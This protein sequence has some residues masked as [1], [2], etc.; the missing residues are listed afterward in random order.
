M[1]YYASGD[2]YAVD[3]SRIRYCGGVMPEL[4]TSHQKPAA[5]WIDQQHVGNRSEWK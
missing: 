2:L 3:S 4:F 1:T 5:A